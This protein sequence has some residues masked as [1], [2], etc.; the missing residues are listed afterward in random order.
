MP[1]PEPEDA[2][3]SSGK[4]S[5]SG[6]GEMGERCDKMGERVQPR[7]KGSAEKL[8]HTAR[9]EFYTSFP[10]RPHSCLP[11]QRFPENTHSKI[12]NQA[13]GS[14][15][16]TS[17][18]YTPIRSLCFRLS[19]LPRQ[20]LALVPFAQHICSRLMRLANAKRQTSPGD[21]ELVYVPACGCCM[22][23]TRVA[24]LRTG[25]SLMS[26]CDT[27]LTQSAITLS[28]MFFRS[29]NVCRSCVTSNSERA[30]SGIRLPI[31][32]PTDFID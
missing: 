24:C 32:S 23:I 16:V 21:N 27:S 9:F 8:R 28:S 2:D 12:P 11:P 4:G 10:K 15:R 5:S 6:W 30:Y 7:R 25:C 22:A 17:A 19:G 29:T 3:I 18:R 14:P 26:T 13:C 1:L 31:S 20:N